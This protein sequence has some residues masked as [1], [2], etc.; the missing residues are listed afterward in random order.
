[1]QR[2]ERRRGNPAPLFH[3]DGREDAV[4]PSVAY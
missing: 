1:M 3:V 2:L 4:V